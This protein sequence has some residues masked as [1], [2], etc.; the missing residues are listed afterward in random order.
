MSF[1]ARGH[2]L[3]IE[4]VVDY[5][6]YLLDPDGRVV[7]WNL[8]AQRIKGYTAPEILGQNFSVFYLPDDIASGI[9]NRALEAARREG[10]FEA[11]GWRR[12]KDGSR[13]WAN[14][15]L[16]AVHDAN[17]ALIGFA[18]VTRD[19]TERR[20]AQM[21]LE[22]SREQLQQVQKMELVG[23][24]TSGLAHDFNNLLTGIMGSLDMLER[25]VTQGRLDD[26]S[27][28][29]NIA[30]Q[31]SSRAAALTQRL[32]AVTRQ[33]RIADPRPTDVNRLITS[34]G[35]LVR[36]TIGSE[37]DFKTTLQSNLSLVSC[38]PT[39]FEHAIL[40]LC[41]NA[42]DAMPSG[43]CLAIETTNVW[44]DETE[45][46]EHGLRSGQYVSICVIDTGIGMSPEVAEQAFNPLF[47]TKP[48][49]KGTGLGLSIVYG[50]ARSAG[51][52]AQLHTQQGAGT[53]ARIYLPAARPTE[54]G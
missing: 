9:P 42:R 36:R 16:T 27:R 35:E 39:Q 23:Q 22:Q 11:E 38:D 49:G 40:N 29:I 14:A 4:S 18:K 10:R 13:F 12:R 19:L 3:L 50:F 32:L 53:T 48:P 41:I 8:G 17:G 5:A 31:A 47:T 15:V 43:G 44:L 37:I 34:I 33:R 24:L 46:G 26:L 1:T 54:S 52:H 7:G 6:I 2:E 30:Q 21:E 51:G 25:H 20:K 45:A 28:Y